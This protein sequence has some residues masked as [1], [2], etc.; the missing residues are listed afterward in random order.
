MEAKIERVCAGD[1]DTGEL[2]GRLPVFCTL[3]FCAPEMVPITWPPKLSDVGEME[4]SGLAV[5]PVPVSGTSEVV[6]TLLLLSVMVRLALKVPTLL[7]AKAMP[8][9]QELPA[10]RIVPQLS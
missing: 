4:I 9:T 8:M 10:R 3:I 5:V 2:K 6:V 7:G 1:A